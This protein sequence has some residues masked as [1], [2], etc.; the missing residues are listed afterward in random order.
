MSYL[1]VSRRIAKYLV[2]KVHT[3]VSENVLAYAVEVLYLNLLSV[4]A[5]VVL[6]LF[7]G[8][9]METIFCLGTVAVTR[10]FAGG[11]HSGSPARC[12]AVTGLVFP[13]LGFLAQRVA[14][15]NQALAS[16]M[17]ALAVVLGL[18]AMVAFAPVDSPAAPII[19]EHR[20]MQLRTGSIITTVLLAAIAVAL[21]QNTLSA[22]ISLGVIWSAFILTPV[23]HQLFHFIDSLHL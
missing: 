8:V 20:R 18:A 16:Y 10:F 7:L 11:A 6:S 9:P 14:M 19:S 17:P 3:G 2:T 1:V 22:A 23:A 13:S 15:A 12:T 4:L 21:S 5:A